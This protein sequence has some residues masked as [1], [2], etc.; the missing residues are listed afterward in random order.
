MLQRHFRCKLLFNFL[1]HLGT[2]VFSNLSHPWKYRRR[3][4]WHRPWRWWLWKVELVCWRIHVFLQ[5]C[6]W[7]FGDSKRYH[8]DLNREIGSEVTGDGLHDLAY[9]DV[10]VVLHAHSLS[11][12]PHRHY[13]VSVWTR[14]CNELGEQL[15]SKMRDE[16]G[17]RHSHEIFQLEFILRILCFN[18]YHRKPKQRPWRIGRICSEDKDVLTEGDT[19]DPKWDQNESD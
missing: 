14:P 10:S 12:L 3:P 2:S 11:Q 7:R 18:R 1:L 9:L 15:Y 6:N 19:Q 17:G 16:L 8:L 5:D 13:L 4:F